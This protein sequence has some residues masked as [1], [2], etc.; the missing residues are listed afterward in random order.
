MRLRVP[1]HKLRADELRG[2]DL[3]E[4]KRLLEEQRAELVTLRQKAAAGAL[5][6]PAR[7]REVRKNIARI[8]T[9]MR[10]KAASQQ[11]AKSE[12]T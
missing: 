1:K 6:S 11:A 10:E 12:A 5:E 7:V 8:L 9:I 3:A 2:K 4:L